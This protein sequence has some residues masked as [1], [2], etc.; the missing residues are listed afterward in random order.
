MKRHLRHTFFLLGLIL[1][2]SA[3]ASVMEPFKVMWGSS[4]KALE[5]ARVDA[6]SHTYGC[7]LDECFNNVLSL[8][9]DPKSTTPITKQFFDVFI[10]DRIKKHIVV[11]GIKG[12]V[13]TTEVGIFFTN[14]DERT[15]KVEVTS[16]STSAKKKVAEAI[17]TE[18]SLNFPEIK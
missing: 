11:F 14:I 2:L 10:K 17:F 4:T 6:L 16:L 15:V 1:S 5:D 9:R 3:C 8:A 13:D 7:S 12:N 18:L